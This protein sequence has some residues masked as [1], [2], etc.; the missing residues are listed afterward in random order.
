MDSSSPLT[1]IPENIALGAIMRNKKI[2]IPD[3][4]SEIHPGDELLLFSKSENI[5]IAE[6]LFI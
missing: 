2:N 4:H 3:Q 1:D 6:N 5:E